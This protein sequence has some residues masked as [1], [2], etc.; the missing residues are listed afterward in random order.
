ML[1]F[2]YRLLVFTGVANKLESKMHEQ[3]GN[4]MTAH[5]DFAK[6]MMAFPKTQQE[7]MSEALNRM[8]DTLE[9]ISSML[10][11]DLDSLLRDDT[12]ENWLAIDDKERN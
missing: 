10:T 2:Y 9:S 5:L 4:A 12:P 8:A 11:L 6:Q 7:L 3:L 1:S